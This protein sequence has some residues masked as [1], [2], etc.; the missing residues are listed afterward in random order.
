M[1]EEDWSVTFGRWIQW[2]ELDFHIIIFLLPVDTVHFISALSAPYSLLL[3][4]VL[5]R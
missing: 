5:L 2:N 4:Y 1:T 3:D